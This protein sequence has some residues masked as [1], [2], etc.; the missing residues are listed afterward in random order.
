MGYFRKALIGTGWMGTLRV[1]SRALSFLKLAIVARILTPQDFGVF[2]IATISLALLEILTETGI[3]VFLIQ[4]KEDIEKYLNTAWVVSI[5][6]GMIIAA[7]LFLLSA[8]LSVFF[9]ESRAQ[10]LILWVGL[11]ASIRGFINPAI[12]GFQKKLEFHK[13]FLLR[14]IV[15]FTESIATIVFTVI[16]HS[17]MSLVYGL[18][19]SAIVEV[20]LSFFIV[21]VRPKLKLEKVKLKKMIS[22]GKW[23]T[24]S[25]ILGFLTRQGDDAVVAK[26]INATSLGFYQMAYKFST[27]PGTEI[28]DVL[29][30]VTFP[31]YAK[32]EQ[33]KKRLL[34]AYLKTIL[35]SAS[36]VLPLSTLLFLF[37]KEVLI[38][39]V[40]SQWIEATSALRILSIFGALGALVGSRNAV[41]FALRRQDLV[42]KITFIKLIALGVFIIPF[43]LKLGIIGAAWASLISVIIVTPVTIYYLVK[44]F[45]NA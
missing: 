4:E 40:G 39:V 34:R 14:M 15:I 20:A 28:T 35:V 31:V 44:V 3:Y 2:G 43:T 38:F 1:G 45:K 36:I 12:I 6:R 37:P 22:R 9:N 21:R 25:G 19:V 26:L 23:V 42:S 17:V 27:L 16:T 41:F 18:M 24:L 7:S 10:Q 13:E 8:P 32:I 11:V 5:L 33:D 29:S 30:K